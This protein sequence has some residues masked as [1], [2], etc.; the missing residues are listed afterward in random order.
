VRTTAA[1]KKKYAVRA[2]VEVLVSETA[3]VLGMRRSR[4]RGR[5]KTHFQH[6]ATAAALN[7]KRAA[8]GLMGIPAI[9]TRKTSFA[10]LA[11]V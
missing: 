1:F 11:P 6:L 10:A 5:A 2:G 3:F 4:Y 9:T 7:L 8:Y